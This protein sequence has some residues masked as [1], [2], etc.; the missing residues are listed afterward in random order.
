MAIVKNKLSQ[1]QFAFKV[2]LQT[3]NVYIV[4]IAGKSIIHAKIIYVSISLYRCN[5]YYVITLWY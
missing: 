1:G 3:E 4:L 5:S 2:T